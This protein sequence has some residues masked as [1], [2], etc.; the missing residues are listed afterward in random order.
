MSIANV[1]L[2]SEIADLLSADGNSLEHRLREI[3][4]LDLYRKAGIST[5]K[6][7]SLLGME[8][9]SF[10]RLAGEN[11]IPFFRHPAGE[12]GEEA[13]MLDRLFPAR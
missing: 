9:L 12:I 3:A 1:H 4:V 5:S 7:A 8:Y 2:D 6:A 11:G 10:I 13:E